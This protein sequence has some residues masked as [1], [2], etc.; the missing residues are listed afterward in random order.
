MSICAVLFALF[1]GGASLC[2]EYVD[3]RDILRETNATLQWDTIRKVGAIWKGE[4]VVTFRP[5]LE[6]GVHNFTELVRLG[7]SEYQTGHILFSEPAAK[8]LRALFLPPREGPARRIAAILIDAGHGGKDPGALRTYTVD[9]NDIVVREKDIVLNIALQLRDILQ[10]VYSN[11]NIV[12]TRVQDVFVS[13]EG[14]TE[15]A[16]A[17]PAEREETIL[18]ISLHVNASFNKNAKGFEV[19][20]LPPQYRREGL[21]STSSTGVE[22]PN[23]LTILNTLKEEEY[24]IE[25]ALLGRSI[26]DELTRGIGNVTSN[27]GLKQE[28]WHVVRQAKMPSVLVEVGFLTNQDEAMRL[29]DDAYVGVI[30]RSIGS[31]IISFIEDFER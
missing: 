3:V 18:F 1:S 16:N 19:W 27:R 20:Y 2:A 25:S 12:L 30:S 22:D 11:K 10:G 24:T 23:V 8:N 31:G 21:V 7:A 5:G 17:I 9:G 15:I 6:W 4:E 26:L 13:L 29:K 28:S 14:R